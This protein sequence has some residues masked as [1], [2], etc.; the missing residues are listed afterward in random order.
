MV[1]RR[2][3]VVL[4]LGGPGGPWCVPGGC[5]GDST[6]SCPQDASGGPWPPPWPSWGSL[7]V[8]RPAVVG[9]AMPEGQLG[10]GP[11]GEL[12]ARVALDLAA[13]RHVVDDPGHRRPL[14]PLSAEKTAS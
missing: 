14:L 4:L 6:R 3:M 11:L 9:L 7:V 5:A 8:G 12:P 1:C 2:V 13:G 10:G